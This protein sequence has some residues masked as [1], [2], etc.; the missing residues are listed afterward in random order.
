MTIDTKLTKPQLT[1]KKTCKQKHTY[2]SQA[3]ATRAR[4]R[5]N[6]TGRFFFTAAYQ[7]NVCHLWHLTTEVQEVKS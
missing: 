6:K 4:K 5:R 3:T 2:S 1:S 7:C